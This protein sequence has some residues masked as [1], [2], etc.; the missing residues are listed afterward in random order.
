ME[1]CDMWMETGGQSWMWLQGGKCPLVRRV[2]AQ[3][4]TAKIMT[5]KGG[6]VWRGFRWQ[7]HLKKMRTCVV[8]PQMVED[9]TLSKICIS[10][11]QKLLVP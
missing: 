10:V 7:A 2:L 8:R 1:E 3:T 6:E 5:D 4:P 9:I 11:K